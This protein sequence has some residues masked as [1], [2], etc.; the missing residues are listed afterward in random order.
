M[1]KSVL[2]LNDHYIARLYLVREL[3]TAA[4]YAEYKSAC[5]IFNVDIRSFKQVDK[6]IRCLAVLLGK[7]DRN[8]VE[9]Y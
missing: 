5:G 2:L 3:R 9:Y 8:A 7:I 4:V 1:C 6:H